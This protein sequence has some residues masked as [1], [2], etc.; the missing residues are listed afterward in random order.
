MAFK[1]EAGEKQVKDDGVLRGDL[2]TS[3]GAK[4]EAGD[5]VS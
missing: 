1:E 5:G 2:R 4:L 3:G